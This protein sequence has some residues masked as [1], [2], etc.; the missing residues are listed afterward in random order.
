MS[1]KTTQKFA[2]KGSKAVKISAAK[3]SVSKTESKTSNKVNKSNGKSPLQ[4]VRQR[5]IKGGW[6]WVLGI[7]SVI[8]ILSFSARTSGEYSRLNLFEIEL[9]GISSVQSASDFIKQNLS[10]LS[11]EQVSVVGGNKITFRA[12]S[13][14][15]YISTFSQKFTGNSAVLASRAYQVSPSLAFDMEITNFAVA[16]GLY[17]A[18]S[19][20]AAL[21]FMR[22]ST[23]MEK[24]KVAVALT[25]LPLLSGLTLAAIGIVLSQLGLVTYNPHTYDMLAAGVAVVIMVT[26]F[27]VF[28][29]ETRRKLFE[30]TY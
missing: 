19:A 30:Y 6:I 22:K 1:N 25:G 13:S 16:M 2:A 3:A 9:D 27:M 18:G 7:V 26:L 21:V 12:I 20:I 8:I 5:L 4:S 24:A 15:E 29:P 23:L 14:S 10:E 17:L 28:Y 11:A